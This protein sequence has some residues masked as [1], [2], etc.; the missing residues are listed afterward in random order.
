MLSAISLTTASTS[1]AAIAPIGCSVKVEIASPMAPS[2][3]MAAATYRVTKSTRSSPCPSGTVFPDSSVT[4]PIGNS[5]AP[6]A[7][8]AA[9]TTQQA[10]SPNTTIAAYLAASSRARPAG[11]VS[12]YIS[13]PSPA[14]PATESP[15]TTATASGSTSAIMR[16]MAMNARNTPLPASWLMKD[17]PASPPPPPRGAASRSAI[18]SRTGRAART[19]S[20]ARLR[21]RRKTR[22]SSERSRRSQP[23][24]APGVLA[25]W[26]PGPVRPAGGTAVASAV[27][28]EPLPG[29]PD[30]QVLQVGPRRVQPGDADTRQHELTADALGG[31]VRELGADLAVSRP[32]VGQAQGGQGLR[33]LAGLRGADDDPAA[34]QAPELVQR[35]LEHQPPGPH[36]PHVGADLL[37]LGEQVG[38]HQD[39]HAVGG[40]LPDEAADLTGALR[41]QAVG[42]LV[43][44]DQL[45]RLEQAGRDRQALLHAQRV[46]PVTLLRRAEQAHPVQG[47]VDPG[48]GRARIGGPV[49]RVDPGQV[50]PAGQVRVE[51]RALDQRP[52]PRQDPG[53]RTGDRVAEQADAA[54]CWVDQ[55]EQHPD[56]G[57]LARSVRPE[58]AV[59]G[60]AGDGEA[61]IVHRD[62]ATAE[63]LGQPA[64]GDR[65]AGWAGRAGRPGAGPGAG[66]R[67]GAGI[68]A[69]A[70]GAH[71]TCAAALYSTDG[72]TA[73]IRT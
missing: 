31:L 15:E 34:A 8:D 54:P 63:T 43:Q 49:G 18:P 41:V 1:T 56:G 10:D 5:A 53:G 42:R 29:Q 21:S 36:H 47:R 71:L 44:D 25:S 73:P 3:A 62:L 23:G 9:T 67:R 2:A 32:D 48:G 6:V 69:G 40:D 24:T 59:H 13:V 30:E 45:P 57:G 19:A 68:G 26:P 35:A 27:D 39:G 66:F 61:E 72:S 22:R 37:H 33:R 17:D 20:R 14:S 52:D 51:G 50:G 58:E 46:R 16:V 55:A 4:G 7:S 38:R 11:T 60:C 65:R 70:S 28:I 64:G 12:R